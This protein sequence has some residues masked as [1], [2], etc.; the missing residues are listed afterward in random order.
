MV[1]ALALTAPIRAT[2]TRLRYRPRIRLG[3]IAP[4]LLLSLYLGVATLV[5]HPGSEQ[6]SRFGDVASWSVFL[7]PTSATYSSEYFMVLGAM[8]WCIAQLRPRAR[9]TPA[10]RGILCLFPTETP[11]EWAAVAPS[12][13]CWRFRENL[14]LF[15]PIK[16]TRHPGSSVRSRPGLFVGTHVPFQNPQS[17]RQIPSQSTGPQSC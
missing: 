11:G 12:S 10:R 8:S 17:G 6:H 13:A 5:V 14:L 16:P 1:V 7:G 2:G 4:A 9:H 3:V 15:D